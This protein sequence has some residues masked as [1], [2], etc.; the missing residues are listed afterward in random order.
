[1]SDSGSNTE[2]DEELFSQYHRDEIEV[3]D[4]FYESDGEDELKIEKTI[5][6]RL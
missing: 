5:Y 4:I 1:M 6:S 2:I 3:S